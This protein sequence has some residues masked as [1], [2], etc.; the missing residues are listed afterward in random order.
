MRKVQQKADKKAKEKY[1]Y[2]QFNNHN[3][4]L[5]Q[6]CIT[7]KKQ[8]TNNKKQAN[9]IQNNILNNKTMNKL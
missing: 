7:T 3:H 8:Y 2:K 4:K 5:L 9:I 6:V 1:N